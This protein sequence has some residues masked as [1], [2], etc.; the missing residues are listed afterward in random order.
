MPDINMPVW[1]GLRTLG[2]LK[3][4]PLQNFALFCPELPTC[5]S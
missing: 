1:D 2:E 4:Y 5:K 3:K